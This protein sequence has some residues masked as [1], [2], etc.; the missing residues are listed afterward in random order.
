V[1]NLDPIFA[2][3]DRIHDHYN[4]IAQSVPDGRW[5]ESSGAGAWSAGEVTAH[6]MMAEETMAGGMKQLLGNPLVPTPFLKRFHAPL[7]VSTW[8]VKKVKSPIPLDAN[9]VSA[10][11]AALEKLS[12]SRGETLKILESTRGK[13]CS[14]YR[15]PH[16]FLGSLN[17]YEWFLMIGYHEARHAKQIREIVET[18]HR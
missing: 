7:F 17:V 5:R 15:Y 13:D 8:R 10:K 2:H 1:K 6:V 9:L 11:S 12:A 18:F 3:L 14:A 4:A 16:P